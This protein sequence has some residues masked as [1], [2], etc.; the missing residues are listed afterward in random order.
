MN[1][2]SLRSAVLALL[3][4]VACRAPAPVV[5]RP[6]SVPAPAPAPPK[7]APARPLL[8]ATD[9]LV[10]TA[11]DAVGMSV[12]LAAAI[13]S[14]AT[15]AIR[16]GAAPGLSIAVGRYDR[17]VHLRG[18]GAIDWA[19]SAAAASDSTLYDLASLTKVIATTTIAM[20]LEEDG[21]LDIARAVRDYVPELSAADKAGITVR[22]LLTHSG[23]LEAG[24][25]LFTRAR[26]R[27]EY[28]TLINSRPLKYAPG[29]QTVYSDWDMVLLQAV[30]ERITG[31]TLDQVARARIF[32][33]LGMRDTRFNPDTT[34]A[35][36]RRRIAPTAIDSTR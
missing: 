5:T 4:G 32:D 31:Q 1:L 12:H 10:R 14:L 22:M 19:P 29:T 34:D 15:D 8:Y 26:G 27:T 7:P 21:R 2:C 28:L 16:E 13:D 23:G 11:P 30:I 3:V 36:L 6:A 24:A 20:M 9:V 35:V 18:Y 33:P 17:L 25:D